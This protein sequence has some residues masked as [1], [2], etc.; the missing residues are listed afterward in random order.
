LIELCLCACDFVRW[1]GSVVRV[2][3]SGDSG[4]ESAL[5]T[6]CGGGA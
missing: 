4:R 2:H 5:Y 1:G 3:E 6:V